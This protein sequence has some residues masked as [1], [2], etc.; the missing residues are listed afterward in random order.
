MMR[1][2]SSVR[3]TLVAVLTAFVGSALIGTTSAFFYKVSSG[4][5]SVGA[6]YWT[7]TECEQYAP[8]REYNLLVLQPDP[9]TNGA[10]IDLSQLPG[11]RRN[12][13][14]QRHKPASAPPWQANL[15]FLIIGTHGPDTITG[16]NRPDCLVGRGGNDVLHGGNGGNAGADV[17]D[18]LLGGDGDDELFGANGK[19]VLLGGLGNNTLQGGN[20]PDTLISEDGATDVCDGN[21]GPDAVSGCQDQSA[22]GDNRGSNKVDKDAKGS[23]ATD[24]PVESTGNTADSLQAEP[25]PALAPLTEDLSGLLVPVVLAEETVSE[26]SAPLV[27]S[28]SVGPHALAGSTDPDGDTVAGE[29]GAGG[30]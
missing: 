26:N 30:E 11:P 29:P 8:L 2:P 18:I 19:D 7:P 25:P 12:E 21:R 16:S 17:G 13:L 9:S 3:V 20:A 10:V 6:G 15:G 1:H 24:A 28:G 27:Y 5:A 23:K 4:T 14:E 22:T